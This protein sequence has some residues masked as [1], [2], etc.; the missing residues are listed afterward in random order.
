RTV[1]STLASLYPVTSPP[2]V[3]F[4][5]VNAE[6]LPDISE[7]YDVT[8]VPYCVLQ[9]DGKI[10]ESISGSDAIRVREAIEKYAGVTNAPAGAG[11]TKATIPP[12]LTATPR[13]QVSSNA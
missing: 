4:I 10:L 8:A 2:T 3:S 11:T 9:R 5:S 6:E 12:P 1:L 13:E 7:D